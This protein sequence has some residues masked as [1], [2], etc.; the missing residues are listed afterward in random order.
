MKITEVQTVRVEDHAE[1]IAVLV[2]TDSGIVGLGETCFGP[3][4]V[5][6][7]IHE[8]VAPRLMGQ[9]PLL[10]E[11][12]AKD[13]PAFYVTHGGTGVSTRAHS[14]VDIALW[15]ILG[16]VTQQPL[17][18]LLGGKVRDSAPIYNTCGGYHYGKAEARFRG[19][20]RP[21]GAGEGGGAEPAAKGPYEDLEAF[22]YRAD[23]LAVSL[24]DMGITAMKI[25]PF[26]DVARAN[27]GHH[28]SAAELAKCLA[29]LEKIRGAVGDRMD[30]MIELHGLWR[31]TPAIRICQALAEYSPYWVED[32][33]KLD[34][35]DAVARLRASTDVRFA[36][37][38][39]LAGVHA[40]KRLFDTGAADIVMFDFGWG[41]GISESRRLSA[42]AE[43][44][45]VPIAPHDC[46]GPV[47]LAVG[48]HFSVATDGVLTQETVR[49]YYT[50]WYLDLVTGLPS[51]GAG[52]ITPPATP[53]LG[54]ELRP[55]LLSRPGT[56]TRT[57]AA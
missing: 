56:H 19:T 29:P 52:R 27:G 36:F 40:Y 23:E 1:F 49:A 21:A 3:E 42:L 5:E 7:Y 18:Q 25:W 35:E 6:A 38:E 44:Y 26:D 24:L 34:S 41:G 13:L 10:I 55:D 50:D 16:K 9:D 17:Y 22:L 54:V 33:I 48:A 46:V 32:A 37:G 8:S 51:I 43:A 45:G 15:D 11:K 39:T 12:H 47:A 4:S 14:A 57:T 2:K 20:S 53:G 30:V 31:A 28:I